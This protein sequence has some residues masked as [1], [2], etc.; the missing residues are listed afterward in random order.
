[1]AVHDRK[2]TEA[3]SVANSDV[4]TAHN[5][6]GKRMFFAILQYVDRPTT[7][8][9]YKTIPNNHEHGYWLLH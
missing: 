3:K 6:Q 8:Y 1:M 4:S 9:A 2:R 5:D 7:A